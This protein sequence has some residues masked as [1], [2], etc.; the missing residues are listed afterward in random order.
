[1]K[2]APATQGGARMGYVELP[3]DGPVLVFIHG[4]GSS[5]LPYF[6][7]V[8]A[9]PALA[10]ARSLLVDLLGFGISDRPHD[11]GYTIPEQARAVATFLDKL[12]IAGAHV[13]AHSMGGS[14]A[15]HL[16]SERTDL[17]AGLVTVEPNLLPSRRP[18]VEPYTEET[19]VTKGFARALA[20]CGEAWVATMRLADPVALFRAENALGRNMPADLAERYLR[21]P[22]PRLMIRGALTACHPCEEEIAAAGIPVAT[23]P[24]AGHN[25]MLDNHAAFV[26]ALAAFLPR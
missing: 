16:A 25:T 20:T 21:L 22:M 9:D 2:H 13:V 8:A 1:M 23:I 3:G 14:I 19:F 17:V 5:S 15:I 26:S 11:F 12:N 18:R 24:D 10:G 7:P 6:T 4:L